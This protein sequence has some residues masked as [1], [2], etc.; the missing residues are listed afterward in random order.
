ML[1]DVL[2]LTT[3]IKNGLE[4]EKLESIVELYDY[5]RLL[6]KAL[7]SA[8]EFVNGHFNIKINEPI[9]Q[10]TESF[11]SPES[12][13]IYFSKEELKKFNDD[14]LKF[15][16]E[17]WMINFE[18][19]KTKEILHYNLWK[20]STFTPYNKEKDNKFKFS[21]NCKEIKYQYLV[22]R[23]FTKDQVL[24]SNSEKFHTSKIFYIETIEQKEEL[25][26]NLKIN[27]AHLEEFKL[28]LE[29]YFLKHNI[30]NGLFV[31][32][33]KDYQFTLTFARKSK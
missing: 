20:Y 12:K 26:A 4:Q 21:S 11:L 10:E 3:I 9:F 16:R 6:I 22:L 32:L 29:D 19:G 1:K 27:L 8:Y 30:P 24:C 18:Q 7:D 15:I 28:Y 13:W 25:I 33:E 2:N 14:M 31:K 17:S 23:K 5:Y